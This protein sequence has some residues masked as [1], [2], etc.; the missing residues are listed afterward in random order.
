VD[1]EL[2]YPPNS[3]KRIRTLN[4][5]LYLAK[6]HQ[7]TYL[8]HRNADPEETCRAEEFFRADGIETVVLNQAVVDGRKPSTKR[9]LERN[10]ALVQRADWK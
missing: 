10:S 5:L 1:E 4:L 7:I 3:G 9:M 2:P 8:C 6:R